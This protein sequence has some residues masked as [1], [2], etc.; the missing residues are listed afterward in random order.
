ME[1]EQDLQGLLDVLNSH[2]DH[3][4]NRPVVT[5]NMVMANPDFETIKESGFSTYTYE[6]FTETY[7]RNPATANSFKVLQQ[8]IQE[9]LIVPQ[10][11]AREHLNSILWMQYLQNQREDFHVAFEQECFS[12]KDTSPTNRRKNIMASYDY[13]SKAD[14]QTIQEAIKEGVALFEEVFHKKSETTIAP[15]YVWNSKVEKSFNDLGIATFQGSKYQ[16]I[17]L[18]N[19]NTFKRKLRYMGQKESKNTYLIRNCLFE[20]AINNKIDWVD[21]C[22]ESIRVA[23][24]WNKPAIIGSHR[25]NFSGGIDP[26]N[27]ETNLELLDSLLSQIVAMWPDVAFISSAELAKYYG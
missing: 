7:N 23:F 27:R 9:K 2:K 17:P 16:N 13:Y 5:A 14:L 24:F 4:G 6:V 18:E 21:A 8:G 26:K 11:H 25:I 22:M 20:P 10:F 3:L 19:T 12:I 1:S 15:C